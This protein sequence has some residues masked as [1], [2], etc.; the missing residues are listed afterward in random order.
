[1]PSEGEPVKGKVKENCRSVREASIHDQE[2]GK[3]DRSKRKE[4][5]VLYSKKKRR[6]WQAIKKKRRTMQRWGRG[7]GRT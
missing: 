4:K 5:K 1:M 2:K 7:G 6:A 3:N